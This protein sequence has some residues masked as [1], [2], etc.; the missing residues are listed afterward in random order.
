MR[1]RAPLSAP[2]Q[3]AT[4]L[5]STLGRPDPDDLGALLEGVDVAEALDASSYM[6]ALDLS[7][8]ACLVFVSA[9]EVTQTC[10]RDQRARLRGCSSRLVALALEQA[11]ALYRGSSER[12][13][14]IR[15]SEAAKRELAV[16]LPTAEL[17]CAQA[18]NLL[19]KVAHDEVRAR[20]ADLHTPCSSADKLRVLADVARGLLEGAPPNIATRTRLYGIDPEF[21]DG[22]DALATELREK[23]HLAAIV[24][25]APDVALVNAHVATW[26][27]AQHFVETFALAHQLDKAIGVLPWTP[28]RLA[29]THDAHPPA[30]VA[31][32]LRH[33]ESPRVL[34]LRVPI[35]LGR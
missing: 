35:A 26:S 16:R 19:A 34:P 15:A 20:L 31:R 8:A 6:S 2:A 24:V 1:P 4:R 10:H 29:P 25:A 3:R 21:A 12:L 22:L 5:L 7:N 27:L 23:S 32:P 14:R 30:S 18:A 28:R 33:V 11:L 17:Q 13:E 9:Y